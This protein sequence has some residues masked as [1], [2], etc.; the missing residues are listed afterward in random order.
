MNLRPL[1]LLVLAS[2]WAGPARAVEKDAPAARPKSPTLESLA[3]DFSKTELGPLSSQEGKKK[4]LYTIQLEK[5]RIM[6]RL[7]RVVYGNAYDLY[8][9]GDFEGSRELASKVLAMDPSFQDAAILHKAAS[10]L[11]GASKP[12]LSE[13]KWVQDRFDEGLALYRQGRVVEASQRWEEAVKLSPGN[14]KARYWLKKAR[15][16]VAEEHFQRGQKAYRQHQLRDTLEQWYAALVLNPKYPRLVPAISK[17]EAELRRQEANEKLQQALDLYGRGK[18]GEA[19]TMLDEVLQI[20]PGEAKA[21]KLIAE[22]RLEIAAQHVAEGRKLYKGRSYTRAIDEWRKAVEFGYDPRRANLLISRARSQMRRE[23]EAR[24]EAE[25]RRKEEEERTRQEEERKRQEEE[26]RRRR[27]EE[28]KAKQLDATPPEAAPAAVGSSEE[29]RKAAIQHWNSGIIYYQ[30]GDLAKARDEWLLC[31]QLD[32]GSSDCQ[33]G[34]QRIDQ[35]Y[36]RGP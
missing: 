25:R 18:T 31:K 17:V 13:R 12:L 9:E 28:E 6:H 16:E 35:T 29:N 32:P 10:E 23:A 19:L 22:I 5:S 7:L 11:K 8:R 1:A 3:L 27:E 14:L 2:L 20:D 24:A 36:E 30:K 15:N 34:L 21:Q 33:T 4:Y 26:E